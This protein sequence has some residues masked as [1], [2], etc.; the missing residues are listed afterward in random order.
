MNVKY[1]HEAMDLAM[2]SHSVGGIEPVSPFALFCIESLQRDMACKMP[3]ASMDRY[4]TLWNALSDVEK[5]VMVWN[6]IQG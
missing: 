4:Q 2:D 5:S 6:R 3:K 1:F